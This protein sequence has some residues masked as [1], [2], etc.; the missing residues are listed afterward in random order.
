LKVTVPVGTPP[1]PVTTAVKVTACP[2]SLPVPETVS[3]M[4][5]A[6]LAT[7]CGSTGDTEPSKV[8]SP[9]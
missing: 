5:V 2:V 7:L 3:A 4:V 8:P 1:G 6:D 9:A